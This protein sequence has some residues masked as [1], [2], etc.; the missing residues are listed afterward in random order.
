MSLLIKSKSALFSPAYPALL[1]LYGM[2]FLFATTHF[3]AVSWSEHVTETFY[4][5]L[6]GW[7]SVLAW[8]KRQYLRPVNLLDMLLINFILLVSASLVLQGGFF[9]G[10]EVR[11]LSAFHGGY[12]LSL[13]AIDA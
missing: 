13:W 4:M 8:W 9:L 6:L 2:L 5:V 1:L 10:G 7:V 12:S 11:K 3:M